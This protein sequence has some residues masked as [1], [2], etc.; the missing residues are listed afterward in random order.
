[1]SNMTEDIFTITSLV[2]WLEKQPS[3]I[4]YNYNDTE[5]CLIYQYLSDCG[6]KV[7]CVGTMVWQDLDGDFHGL[8]EVF[9]YISKGNGWMRPLEL[10]TYGEALEY[11]KRIP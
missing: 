6:V 7:R 9:N 2:S 1:M 8:P 11:A 3:K 10:R 5:G 4:T